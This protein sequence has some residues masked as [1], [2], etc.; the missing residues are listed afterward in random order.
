MYHAKVIS[1]LVGASLLVTQPGCVL[2][3]GLR[4]V[5][6]QMVD[7]RL[8]D[9]Q[10]GGISNAEI[11]LLQGHFDK[12]N[13]KTAAYLSGPEEAYQVDRAV[14][15]TDSQ[16]RFSHKFRGF[17]HC[18]P[19]WIL[20]PLLTLPSK[21]SGET[22]HG[23]FFIMMTP[24]PKAQIYEIAVGKSRPS[25]WVFDVQRGRRIRSPKTNRAEVLNVRSEMFPRVYSSGYTSHVERVI[26][27]IVKQ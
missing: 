24:Q 11:V 3:G 17:S 25:I 27:E 13:T 21:V 15:R 1:I 20:P 8:V 2:P 22:R 7:G 10:G 23:T 16:G 6:G 4:L 14:V 26:L 9:A 12:L 18:H 5:G 19:T